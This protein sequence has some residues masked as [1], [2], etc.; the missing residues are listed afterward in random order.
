MKLCLGTVQFGLNYGIENKQIEINEID[1]I[2]TTALKKGITILDTAQNYG[3]SE[4]LIGN[5]KERERFRII[6]K[7]SSTSL[8]D[9]T[10]LE[11]LKELLKK[12]LNNLKISCLD[13]L[14]LHKPEDLNNE[15]FL[16]NLIT[17]KKEGYFLN[18]GISIYS[19]DEAIRA[20]EFE[21]IK[22]IQIPYN[23]L[24]TR[25]DK[26]DFFNKAK[27][28]NKILFARSI[29]LQ[30][31]LL[32]EHSKYPYFLN[33]LKKFDRIIKDESVKLRSTK[34][35]FL[36]NFIK[37]NKKIDYIVIGID[38]LENLLEIINAYNY[39]GLEN[40]N[41]E[42]FRDQFKNISENILNPSLWGK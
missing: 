34:L 35:E 10:S 26:V 3:N 11:E 37:S 8:K 1:K 38:S 39:E 9:A 6:S 28:K 30:G 33:E 21:N 2:L 29:F 31:T 17:L 13:G 14:L 25:L 41:Y 19:T 12:S 40:Y 42:K 5:F 32:K 23:I 15:L 36:I 22:Y 24:D 20:L 27:E 16:Y 4:K 7:I 18:L